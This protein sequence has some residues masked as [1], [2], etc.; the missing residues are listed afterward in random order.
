MRGFWHQALDGGA[1]ILDSARLKL[2]GGYGSRRT[3]H[4]NGEQSIAEA[5]FTQCFCRQSSDVH[6]LGIPAG[7]GMLSTGEDSHRL[8][9]FQFGFGHGNHLVQTRQ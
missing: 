9:L 5:A 4:K 7:L 2:D 8:L 1:K 3:G 6:Y